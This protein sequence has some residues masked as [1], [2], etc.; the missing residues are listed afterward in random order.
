MKKTFQHPISLFFLLLSVV[1]LQAQNMELPYKEIPAHSEAYT[2]GNLVARMIDGLGY[3]FYWATEGL[4]DKDLAYKPSEDGRTI[5][6]TIAH[7]NTMSNNI[8]LAPDALPFEKSLYPTPASYEELR[9]STLKNL[10]AASGKVLGKS[11]EEMEKF[12]V[13]FKRGEQESEFAFWNLINGMISDCIYHT[14]QITLMRRASG[15]PQ[16]PNVNPF[17]GQTKGD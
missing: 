12:K 9:A 15:N 5:L 14:G 3:R 7:I 6:E 17:L 11:A 13:I 4:T 1:T 16:N 10:K 8:L 2:S